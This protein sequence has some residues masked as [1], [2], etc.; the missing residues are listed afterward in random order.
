VTGPKLAWGYVLRANPNR[1]DACDGTGSEWRRR[2][3]GKPDR[4]YRWPLGPCRVCHGKGR[5]FI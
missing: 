5:A 3:D 2:K 4:R 1:C